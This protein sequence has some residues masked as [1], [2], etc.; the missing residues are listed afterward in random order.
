MKR[1]RMF[2]IGFFIISIAV[3]GIYKVRT[4]KSRDLVGPVIKMNEGTITVS[5]NATEQDLLAGI[6]AEDNKDGDVTDSLIVESM[7]NFIEK[8]RRNI[9]VAA[10]DSDNHVT[11][12]SREVVYS[13]Y[14]S[15]RFSLEKPLKFLLN[16]NNILEGLSVEDVL[17]GNLTANIKISADYYVQTDTEGD[18]PMIFSVANS[19]GDVAELPVTVEM[20][21]PSGE[22]EILLSEYLVYTDVGKAIEPWDYVQQITMG[23][24]EYERGEDGVF[25]GPE[26]ENEDQER[27]S[28]SREDVRITQNIDYKVPGVSE[29]T[30][31]IEEENKEPGKVRL[32]VVVSE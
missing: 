14:R 4:A 20:Y 30:Y 12:A 19:A 29:I 22:P 24:I 32:I 7:S 28:I 23:G 5:V 26:P 10:V 6:T 9:T 21:R 27:A 15:P 18:Y 2:S 25:Y 16:E 31:E 3:F 11:K 1:M 17:D 8:G 13:D